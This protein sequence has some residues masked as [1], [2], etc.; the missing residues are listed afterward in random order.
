M[1]MPK[2]SLKNVPVA[3]NTAINISALRNSQMDNSQYGS[4]LAFKKNR[5]TS[6]LARE[7][8]AAQ[9]Q[10]SRGSQREKAVNFS[11]EQSNLMSPGS[12][13]RN[14]QGS[15]A[16]NNQAVVNV[17]TMESTAPKMISVQDDAK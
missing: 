15:G 16:I 8:E 10:A 14:A 7:L 17:S 3:A 4:G 12:S 1:V 5:D 11:L 6:P 13:P 2:P 9:R